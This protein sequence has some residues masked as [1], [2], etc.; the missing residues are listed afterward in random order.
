M[1]GFP[2][3]YE[4]YF[5][6]YTCTLLCKQQNMLFHGLY[7]RSPMQATEHAISWA[8]HALSYAS[9]RTCDFMGYTRAL[10][11]KQQ[12][13]RFHGLYTCSPVRVEEHEQVPKL[14]GTVSIIGDTSLMLW[15]L[16]TVRTVLGLWF[17]VG[18][19][20][21]QVIVAVLYLTSSRGHG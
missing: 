7:M 20:F 19:V 12:N 6:G 2:V 1:H 9:N 14:T 18:V 11:C 16:L 21:H 17:V 15:W 10:L 3:T 13:M 8:I 5:M 4:C